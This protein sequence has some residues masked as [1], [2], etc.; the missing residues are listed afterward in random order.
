V[1]DKIHQTRLYLPVIAAF[2]Y[3]SSQVATMSSI[4]KAE[5]KP[6][7]L[8]SL[9]NSL[10]NVEHIVLEKVGN[11]PTATGYKGVIYFSENPS[12]VP[13]SKMTFELEKG[14]RK[15]YIET[16]RLEASAFVTIQLLP[17]PQALDSEMIE[18]IALVGLI[19]EE[20]PKPAKKSN[21][22]FYGITK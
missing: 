15:Y 1:H 19:G 4:L 7:I 13:V 9:N 12:K 14:R 10:M 11:S 21:P 5:Q 20:L 6:L 17:D 8:K 2:E 3:G 16:N 18:E 22:K